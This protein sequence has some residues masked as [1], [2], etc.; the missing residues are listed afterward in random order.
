MIQHRL[1]PEPLFGVKFWMW[2]PW[3]LLLVGFATGRVLLEIGGAKFGSEGFWNQSLLFVKNSCQTKK[4][5]PKSIP[6]LAQDLEVDDKI[7]QTLMKNYES[8]G[9][10]SQLIRRFHQGPRGWEDT[11]TMI[12]FSSQIM[13]PYIPPLLW[14][15]N[16][17]R[18]LGCEYM[19]QKAPCQVSWYYMSISWIQ[20]D[21]SLKKIRIQLLVSCS[22]P[23]ALPGERKT[24]F[25]FN[26]HPRIA[27]PGH[28][29]NLVLRCNDGSA[30]YSLGKAMGP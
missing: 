11:K 22:I 10:V 24:F 18:L 21:R 12:C 26:S 6:Y 14:Q 23:F 30:K 29:L 27:L 7:F 16:P 9:V 25:P 1:Q 4:V 8:S 17:S 13:I 28:F 19:F 15:E 3:G 2:Q 5:I 20:I